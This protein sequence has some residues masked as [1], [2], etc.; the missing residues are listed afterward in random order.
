VKSFVV[1]PELCEVYEAII[2]RFGASLSTV[3]LERGRKLIIGCPE[4]IEPVAD[5]L[6]YNIVWVVPSQNRRIVLENV[7]PEEVYSRLK[8]DGLVLHE[9]AKQATEALLRLNQKVKPN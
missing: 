3:R 6:R 7:T 1:D 8:A 5:G 9:D 4:L 2:V